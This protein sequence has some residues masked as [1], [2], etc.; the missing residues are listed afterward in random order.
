MT[1]KWCKYKINNKMD[2]QYMC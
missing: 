1:I 2:S